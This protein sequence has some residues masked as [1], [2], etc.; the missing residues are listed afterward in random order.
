[1]SC[2][3]PSRCFLGPLR[4]R[5][6]RSKVP[7]RSFMVL[8]ITPLQYNKKLVNLARGLD[9]LEVL[10]GKSRKHRGKST[11]IREYPR[12]SGSNFLIQN[13]IVGIVGCIAVRRYP[14]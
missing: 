7:Y 5:I 12:M 11:T 9:F 1:M 8:C 10:R 14:S 3:V 2:K 6:G 4:S 13:V